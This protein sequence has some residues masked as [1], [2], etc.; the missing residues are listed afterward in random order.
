MGWLAIWWVTVGIAHGQA[1][2]RVLVLFS[3]DRL[4]PA[5]QRYDEGMR[6][7]L[8]PQENQVPVTLFAEFLDAIRLGGA[9][10]EEAMEEYLL[11]R[12]RETAPQVLVALGPQAL[13]FFLKRRDSLFPGVPLVFGGVSVERVKDLKGVAGLPMELTVAPAVEALQAMRP[14]TREIVLVHGSSDFDRSWRDK[15][16]AQCAP[17]ADRVKISDFPE[18]PL[19]ELKSRLSAL[20]E[21]TAVIYLTYFLSPTGETY[22][23]ASVASPLAEASAVPLIGPYDTYIG[24]GLLGVSASPFEEEGM[25]LGK[26]IRRVLSGETVESIGVLPPNPSRVILDARQVERWKIRSLPATAELRFRTPT[27]WEAHRTGVI[28][29]VTVIG[30]QGVLI[31][32]LVFARAHQRRAEMELRLSEARFSG[33]FRGS[34]AAISIVRQSDGRII[35]VNPGWEETTGVPR[36]DAIGRTPVEAG[37]VISGDAEGHF[38]LF[39]ESGKPLHDYEQVQRTPDGRLRVLSLSTELITLQDEPCFIIV[40]KD[41]TESHG[42]ENARQRLAHTSR[43]AM[44]GEMTA[45]IAHEVN[46]PLGAILSNAEAAEM[47]LEQPVPPME[48]VKQILSDIRRDDLRASAVIQRVRALV[49]RREVQ[50]VPL[51]LNELLAG[52]I[53]MVTHEAHRRG[54]SLVHEFADDLPEVFADP[55]QVEQVLLNLLINAMDAMK[56]TPVASRS[57]VVRSARKSVSAVEASVEDSGQGIPPEALERVFDSFFTTKEGGMGLGL[58]LAWSIA[59]AHG[60]A[61][62]AENNTSAGSTFR[63]ILPVKGLSH[64]GTGH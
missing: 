50:R 62:F 61:L 17:F 16:L 58:S 15:A 52:S 35:D 13:D 25:V 3:N 57:I 7:A 32:G 54:V 39:L 19:E 11:K 31:A 20:P 22:T 59:E 36:A 45:S 43:L 46:Q 60:G 27:L 2:P 33:V 49:G 6:R 4:L 38:R 9:E 51:D 63:L 23:P 21:S 53:R 44:L 26:V 10:R 55:V 14:Q 1:P 29:T 48:E 28:A 40:A 5:N 41:V 47:L 12:Y 8:D 30:L 42:A 56:D 37:M 64:D 24:S 34:P 18:L